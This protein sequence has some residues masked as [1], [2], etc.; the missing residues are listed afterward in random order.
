MEEDK[1]NTYRLNLQYETLK[2]AQEDQHQVAAP[3]QRSN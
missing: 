2:Q 3:G 1:A